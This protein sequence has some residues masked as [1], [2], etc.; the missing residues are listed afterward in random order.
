MHL[1]PEI[2]VPIHLTMQTLNSTVTR[3]NWLYKFLSERKAAQ[4][5][6][7]PELAWTYGQKM[8]FLNNVW[9][10]DFNRRVEIEKQKMLREMEMQQHSQHSKVTQEIQE[11]ISHLATQAELN[12]EAPIYSAVVHNENEPLEQMIRFA[13]KFEGGSEAETDV[14]SAPHES[15]YESAE[16]KGDGEDDGI[17]VPDDHFG[18]GHEDDDIPV[19]V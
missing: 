13:K 6:L 2:V 5:D 14:A 11:E 4:K 1:N 19:Q 9:F 7:P 17:E 18:H 10:P 3:L 12:G 16:D 8:D 15:E